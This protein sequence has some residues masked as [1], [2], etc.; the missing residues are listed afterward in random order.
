MRTA[1]WAGRTRQAL[2][3]SLAA[4]ASLLGLCAAC[5]PA[6]AGAAEPALPPLFPIRQG[7][8]HGLIDRDGR[9]VLAAEYS[10]I[11]IGSPWILVS[12]G[13]RVAYADGSGRLV[14]EP[15]DVLSQPYTQGLV[16]MPGKDAQGRMRWGYADAQRR[17][18]IAAAYDEAGP[19][20][21]GL[22]VVGMADEWGKLKYGAIDREGRLVVR[23]VH[24]KLLE[25]AGT[26]VRAQSRERTH[27]VFD[28]TGRDITPA[29]V[30]FVGIPSD[31][32]VRVWSARQQGFMTTA[33]EMVVPPRFAQASD[34]KD[35]VARVWVD[36]KYG[37]IDRRGQMVIEP[38]FS[39]ARP[40][41]QGLAY[42]GLPGKASAYIRPD[43][44]VV[45][46]GGY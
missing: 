1:A 20:V 33:G 42:V 37:Y 36:G 8:L 40:F 34:F 41:Q 28:A 26:L 16:P 38:Q 7:D 3:R 5:P 23:A 17:M 18:V 32:M 15:Q 31:G 46:R 43:G 13:A 44:Q 21:D 9:V 30:D 29:G 45:W 27:R 14:I 10:E 11:R 35:G 19:F 4:V 12:K 6:T 2:R 24:D 22:A 25:P 39:F